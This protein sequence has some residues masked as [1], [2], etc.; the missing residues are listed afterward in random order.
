MSKLD[1]ICFRGA[2]PK[3]GEEKGKPLVVSGTHPRSD[4]GERALRVH[5]R[6]GSEE[7]RME[8]FVTRVLKQARV[9]PEAYRASALAR[10]IPACLRALRAESTQQAGQMLEEDPR[11]AGKVLNA[12]LIGVSEFF[13]DPAVWRSLEEQA[14]GRLARRQTG[15][16]VYSAGCSGGQELYSAAI[17]ASEHRLLEGSKFLGVD[18]RSSAIAQGREGLFEAADLKSMP[19]GLRTRYFTIS[20]RT[21]KIVPQLRA[22]TRWVK[23]DLSTFHEGPWDIILF[24]NVAIYLKPEGAL[25][26]WRCLE[27]QLAPGGMLVTGKACYPPGELGLERLAPCVYRKAG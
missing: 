25:K 1:Y 10:R 9:D 16:R 17:L 4:R 23:A 6:S 22:R 13:R 21:A 27:R 11:L 12:L 19:Q 20:D 2:E 8:P 14:L 15:L 26:G 5:P 3:Q 24:R 7:G 18:C